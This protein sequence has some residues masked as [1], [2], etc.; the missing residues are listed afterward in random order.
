MKLYYT[1]WSPYARKVRVA[2]IER[3]I[4]KEIELIPASIGYAERTLKVTESNL[5]TYNPSGRV[6]TLITNSGEAIFDSTVI[7][8]YLDGI[9]DMAPIIPSNYKARIKALRLNSLVDEVIDAMRHLS[10]EARRAEELRLPDYLDALNSKVNRGLSLLEDEAS[11][12]DP[13]GENLDIGEISIGCLLQSI[14][15]RR[16]DSIFNKERKNLDNWSEKLF[17]KD[18]MLQT[19]PP[20]M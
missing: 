8:H 1:D 13:I 19:E 12:F 6:P 4:D 18:S 16:P 7:I 3:N 10:F 9:G 14:K 11:E 5:T 15:I 20:A 17:S 2:S